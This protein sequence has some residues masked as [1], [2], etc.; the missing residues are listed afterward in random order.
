MSE[1]VAALKI[2]DLLGISFTA[3]TDGR[4]ASVA[5]PMTEAITG[6]ECTLEI[7]VYGYDTKTKCCYVGFEVIG[8]L[9]GAMF[10]ASSEG[11]KSEAFLFL[12]PRAKIG[13]YVSL[14][15]SNK[16][17]TRLLMIYKSCASEVYRHDTQKGWEKVCFTSSQGHST[18]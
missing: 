8:D 16:G 15:K 2:A 4:V 13:D 18:K 14:M 11:S 1:L 6:M 10:C 7:K 5:K 3:Y 12:M 17:S 9:V